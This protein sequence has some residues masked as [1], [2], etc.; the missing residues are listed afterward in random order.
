MMEGQIWVESEVGVGSSFYFTAKF[1]IQTEPYKSKALPWESRPEIKVM[2]VDDNSTNRVI[3]KETIS[4][5]GLPA[6]EV[7]DGPS[8]LDLLDR[9]RT[10]QVP[11]H[12]L[13]LDD[14]MPGMGGIEVARHIRKDLGITDMQIVML[15]SGSRFDNVATRE[16]L[17]IC[18]YLV[19]PVK[20]SDLF[21]AMFVDSGFMKPTREESRPSEQSA[22]PRDPRP[23]S[24]LLVEDSRDNR[25]LIEAYLSKTPH[26]IDVAENGEVAVGKFTSGNYDL[27]LMD[28][29][30]P[31]IDGYAA[32]RFIRRW[33]SV[34]RKDPPTPII[35][36]TAHALKEDVQKSLEAGCTTHITKPVKKGPLLET[37]HE[38]TRS[39]LV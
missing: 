31:V 26:R 8:A 21:Q 38:H 9:A 15:T 28:V 25:L 24:I 34:H 32:T 7:A 18:R 1:D 16:E 10:A 23:L 20:R 4:A 37:I 6:T 29:Q 13:L 19:K 36:L 27:V 30:M 35:A 22:N 39:V 2:I 11:Y 17:D 33:E 3:L 12:L 14:H 5:W